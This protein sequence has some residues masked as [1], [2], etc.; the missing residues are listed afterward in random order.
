MNLHKKG[1]TVIQLKSCL[2]RNYPALAY[3]LRLSTQA[4]NEP[5]DQQKAIK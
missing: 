3:F 5:V 2:E 4:I 1:R